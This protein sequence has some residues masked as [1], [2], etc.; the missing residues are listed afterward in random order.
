M[1]QKIKSIILNWLDKSQIV[2]GSIHKSDRSGILY[3]A[4]GHVF[5]NHLSGDYVEFG[6]YQGDSLVKS[7]KEYTKFKSWIKGQM[8]S[9]ELWRREVATHYIEENVKFH[10]LDTFSGMPENDEANIT[11]KEGTFLSDVEKVK[12]F[13]RKAGLKGDDLILYKGLFEDTVAQL[14]ENL[15]GRKISILNIDS[16]LYS[17]AK[18][19]LEVSMPYLGLGSIILFDDYN[20]YAASN[21]EG[22]RKAFKEFQIESEFIWESWQA[23]HFSGQAFLCVDRK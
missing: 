14:S 18:T 10:A 20:T 15:K 1:I 22:E 21:T 9:D 4:W 23:Y 16:D 5:T 11:F 2:R 7:H 17:S 3:K 13:C 19:A 6:V 8:T 12:E